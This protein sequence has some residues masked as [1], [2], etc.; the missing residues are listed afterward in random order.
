[1]PSES[2]SNGAGWV[3]GAKMNSRMCS[4]LQ[5]QQDAHRGLP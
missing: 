3:G 5:L 4:L 1:M 2:A